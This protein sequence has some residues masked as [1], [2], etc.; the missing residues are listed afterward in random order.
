MPVFHTKTIESIL[1]PVAQQVSKLVILHEEA[2]DGIPMPDLQQPVRSVSNAVSNLVKVG[3]ETI[4]SSDDPILRQDMPAAL[5]RV[6]RS[7]KLLEEASDMLKHD[8]FSSPARKRLIEGSGGILQATSAL[9]LCFDESEVRK[10]IKEC[11]RVL[12]YLAVAEVIETLDELV[13]F[14]RD[15][16]PCLSKVSREV[17]AREKELTHQLKSTEMNGKYQCC[18]EDYPDYV[19]IRCH[20]VYHPCCVD[21]ANVLKLDGFQIYCSLEC[22]SRDVEDNVR[23]ADLE[24]VIVKLRKELAERSNYLKRLSKTF[25]Q[26]EDDVM[27]KENEYETTLLQQQEKIKGLTKEIAEL[28]RQKEQSNEKSNEHARYVQKLEKDFVELSDMYK[29]MVSTI[30]MLECD[31]MNYQKLVQDFKTKSEAEEAVELVESAPVASK[32]EE[33]SKDSSKA[34][35]TSDDVNKVA[36]PTNDFN[37]NTLFLLGYTC[38]VNLYKMLTREVSGDKQSSVKFE[39]VPE[40][41][42]NLVKSIAEFHNLGKFTFY[43]FKGIFSTLIPSGGFLQYKPLLVHSEILVRCLEQVKTLAPILICSMKIYIHIVSQ[44]GKGAEEAAENRN[45]LAQRMTDEINEIIRVLQ[46]TS[47]DEEQSE[48]DNLT[49]L[50]KLQNAISNKINAANDWLFDPNAVRGG[51]GEKSLRQIIEAAQKV[52]DRCLPNDAHVINKLCSDLTTMTDALCELRQDGKGATPQAES[53]ARGIREKL[54]N[55][56]QAV[57]NA[58]V[59][60]DKTGLQQTA[61]TVQ[62]RL[63]QARKWLSNPGHDDKGLGKRAIN[64]IVEEGRR[65]ADGLPGVQKAEILQLCDEVDGLS[66]QLADLCAQGLGNSPQA[67]EVAR[68]LSQKLH[69]LK[70]KINQAVVNRVVEDFID[71]LTP[72]KVF[73]EAVLAPEGT[74]N[75]DLNFSDKA[76]NLQQF[77][78]RAVKTAK[79]VAAGGSSGNKKLA[80]A[81]QSAANQVESLTP[82]LISAGSIRMN[83]PTSKAA[84]EHF[85]NLRQQYADTL[86]RVRNLCDEATDSADFIKASEEQMRKHTFLCEEGI[87]NRQPQKMVDNTSAIARLAN[88]VLLVAKQECENS[89]DPSFI[90]NLDRASDVLQNSIPP[91]VQDAKLVAINPADSH[92]A[93]KW[94]DSNKALLNAVG[95]VRQAVQVNPELPPLPDINSLNLGEPLRNTPTPSR[96]LEG[97]S[98]AGH[99][100]GG[101]VSPLPKWARGDNSDL[102]CQELASHCQDAGRS[103]FIPEYIIEDEQAPPRPPLPYDGAPVR[104]PPPPETDDEDEVFKTAP[105]PSQP[106]MVAAHNLHREVRQWSAKDNELI[107]AAQRMAKLMARLSELVHNDDKGSKRELI[108]TAKAIADASADVTRI[109]KQ[110]ARECTDKRIRTN[111]LQVC[112]RIPTIATQLKILSTVKATMLGSQGSEEDREATEMLE[113]NA[114]NLMQ[115]V[116]ETVRA[117]ESASVK[118]HAQT[119]GRLRWVRKQPWYAY[120]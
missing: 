63:E 13:Q 15:L 73:T 6:E 64:A 55:L 49:V 86:T 51:V 22:E 53:L 115:S 101:R 10:I 72:L 113:G 1:D 97:L 18:K 96:E 50:K 84:D 98:P 54:G 37:G 88:R 103:Q 99:Q 8:P 93:S 77:S 46:L 36:S 19:C 26:F 9:L 83:Y 39:N 61:H 110:L 79:M 34:K 38:A 116:K 2:E 58:V 47:Y 90:N 42:N 40:T 3:R 60:V 117:A 29:Q 7:S 109:A 108:A 85:E 107:A 120:A 81:L 75:R 48:L 67:Q 111:L 74:P 16:S 100:H 21:G 119:H 92:A 45:Y 91:M 44:G 102:L 35:E 31:N 23:N 104:P 30:R 52:A 71:I 118:I 82:Q 17:S 105:L 32:V 27:Y 14:L 112:E 95:N 65:V 76:A 62:G 94:R 66:R 78:N 56:Q 68:K 89:E 33:T 80:E 87:K 70:E 41:I 24:A 114:Q 43:M 11:H 5:V 4:N 69:E 25:L 59:A 28:K 20:N 12:D 57:M 106:I